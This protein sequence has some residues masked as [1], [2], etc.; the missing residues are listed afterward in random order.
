MNS[1]KK[2]HR[3]A[4]YYNILIFLAGVIVGYSA[5]AP[6]LIKKAGYLLFS[7]AFILIARFIHK[8]QI[9]E[10]DENGILGKVQGV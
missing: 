9:K 4:R 8:K 6:T 3:K 5:T 7:I 2:S 10:A 1:H